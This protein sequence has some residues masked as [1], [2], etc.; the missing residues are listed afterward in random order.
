V[1]IPLPQVSL[2]GVSV[3]QSGVISLTNVGI[4]AGGVSADPSLT[5]GAG[6]LHIFNES[7]SGLLLQ[8]QTG[9]DGFFLPA[10]GWI[11]RPL[12]AGEQGLKYTILYNLPS[13]PVTLLLVT[14]YAPN[15]PIPRTPTL[16]NSPIGIGGTVNTSSVQTLSNE[17]NATPVLV[18]DIGQSG[19]TQLI[20]INS[21]GSAIWQ[22]LQ[23]G[24]AHTAFTVLA[25]GNALQLGQVGDTVQVLGKISNPAGTIGGLQYVTPYKFI[26]AG[27]ANANTTYT[28]TM[29][30][31]GGIPAN[32]FWVLV[33]LYWTAAAANGYA[34]LGRQG[35]SLSTDPL[36]G[37][38]VGQAQGGSEQVGGTV[39]VPINLSNGQIA[40]YFGLQGSTAGSVNASVI[41]Y[42]A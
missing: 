37:A 3:G 22:V 15:E 39:L 7:G 36:N 17:N 1:S 27:T 18:I 2:A 30:G 29:Q 34:T 16:G 33:T 42:I 20:T 31:N 25:S 23:S 6:T 32:A 13:P 26:V 19:H 38:F 21:D 10:G 9:S 11:D 28:Y 5:K 14:Y 8:F 40:I 24:V 4:S 12:R 35:D 41:G